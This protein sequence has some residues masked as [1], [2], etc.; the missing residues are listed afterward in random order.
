MI[1]FT[2]KVLYRF[3]TK[4]VESDKILRTGALGDGKQKTE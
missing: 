4:K 2:K 3:C 1:A